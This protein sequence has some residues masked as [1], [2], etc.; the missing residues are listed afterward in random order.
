MAPDLL[1]ISNQANVET[2][3]LFHPILEK[4]V[5]QPITEEQTWQEWYIRPILGGAN[6]LLYHL[7]GPS[8]DFAVK[9]SRRDKRDRAGREYR[10]LKLI[11]LAGGELAPR[12]VLLDQANY[13]HD[14]IIQT[15]LEGETLSQP[16]QND[17][18]WLDLIQY[19][20]AIHKISPYQTR[21][22][23]NR[24]VINF[25]SA[26]QASGIIRKQARRIPTAHQPPI[27]TQLLQ[28]LDSEALPC[29]TRPRLALC[30]VDANMR[31]FI[32]Q[33]G[34]KL[35]SVDWENSG[36]GD[37]IFEIADLRW[38]PAYEDVSA[39]RWEWVMQ[40]YLDTCPDP[41]ARFRL[42]VYVR[43][44]AI[45]WVVRFSRYLY[46]IPRGLDPRLATH[47]PHVEKNLH[48]KLDNYSAAAE[49]IWL[50][51]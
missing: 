19:F 29:W 27:L 32:R 1:A 34:N 10:A 14:V 21:F 47:P 43:L 36:W 7:S 5:H 46:E 3:A 30:R 28:K 18:D 25:H 6:S 44:M 37:P 20:T 42:E 35:A 40:R 31:N 41:L 26:A 24:A 23:L 51:E 45:W 13:A 48:A 39:Q 11:E 9:V 17:G 22:S 49:D 2:S 33:P 50:H 15:W 8:G 16:P 38:H 12:A 4:I